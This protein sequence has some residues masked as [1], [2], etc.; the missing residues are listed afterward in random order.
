M[1]QI[2]S[3]NVHPTVTLSGN[4]RVAIVTALMNCSPGNHAQ[5]E[6]ELAQGSVSGQVRAVAV[7]HGEL[8]RGNRGRHHQRA[9]RPG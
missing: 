1:K 6:I 7:C 5:I 3:F 2:F 4:G 8:C 9:R